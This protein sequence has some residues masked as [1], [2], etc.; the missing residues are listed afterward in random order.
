M[1]KAKD[2]LCNKKEGTLNSFVAMILVS[3]ALVLLFVNSKMEMIDE[4]KVTC[5]DAL[6]SS[7]LAGAV[8]N[9]EEYGRT[10]SIIIDD[11]SKC[12]QDFKNSLDVNLKLD[13]GNNSSY[14]S[15]FASPIEVT[16]F[17]IYNVNQDTGKIQIMQGTGSMLA[18]T[19]EAN[20][21]TV[22]APDGTLIEN[23]SIY[24]KI[25]FDVRFSNNHIIHADKDCCVDVKEN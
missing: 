3:V 12:Y 9:I 25:K 23:T 22:S 13:S 21:G 16:D 8:V 17:I 14:T 2:F 6:V 4:M 10:R 18:V 24:S 1:K 5:E 15:F 11:Y 20:L 7:T 19:Y